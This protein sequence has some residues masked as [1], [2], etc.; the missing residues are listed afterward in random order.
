MKSQ[1]KP[2]AIIVCIVLVLVV[3]AA[4]GIRSLNPPADVVKK[5]STEAPMTMNGQQV[6]RE[7]AQYLKMMQ[8]GRSPANGAPSGGYQGG[9]QA[10]GGTAPR[11]MPGG[12][13][14]AQHP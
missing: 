1:V 13:M 4:I 11:S 12:G 3:I 8:N 10:P 2:A 6:P 14:P 7:G 5:P 9:Y